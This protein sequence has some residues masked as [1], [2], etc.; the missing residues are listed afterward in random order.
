MLWP[1]VATEVEE[2]QVHV[3]FTDEAARSLASLARLWT[4]MSA[5]VPATPARRAR[6][7]VILGLRTN[8]RRRDNDQATLCVLLFSCLPSQPIFGIYK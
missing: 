8:P 7:F 4:V 6:I 1:A 2:V 5:F 3:K